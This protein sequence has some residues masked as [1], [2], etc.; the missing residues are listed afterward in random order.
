M[1]TNLPAFSSFSVKDLVLAKRFYKEVLG[2]DVEER[3]E[4]LSLKWPNMMQVFIYPSPTNNP[5]EFTVLNFIV[6]D[7]ESELD[8]LHKK[9]VG[10]EQYSTEYI[11]TDAKGISRN[12]SGMG[13]RAMAWFKDPSG[14]ILALLQ[15]K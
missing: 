9:G 1:L 2:L 13:P 3:P 5:A 7:I 10:F 4:G 11:K 14:N 15:E 6:G 12:E 8:E